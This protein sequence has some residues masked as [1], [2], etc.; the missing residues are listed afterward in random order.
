MRQLTQKCSLKFIQMLR[1]ICIE[2]LFPASKNKRMN[3][4]SNAHIFTFI[5]PLQVILHFPDL[6]TAVVKLHMNKYF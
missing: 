5:I 6:T 1:N 2:A 3:G 4:C